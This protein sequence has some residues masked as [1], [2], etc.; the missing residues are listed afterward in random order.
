MHRISHTIMNLPWLE[1]GGE[2]SREG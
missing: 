2:R 1:R